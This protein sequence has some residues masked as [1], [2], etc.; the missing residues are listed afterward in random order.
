LHFDVDF[1]YYG[2]GE[3]RTLAIDD[4]M[5]RNDIT[6]IDFIKIAIAGMELSSLKGSRETIEKFKP[7]LAISLYHSVDDY[8]TIPN[9]LASLSMIDEVVIT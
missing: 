1:A 5:I 7:K 4:F 2:E 9:Y 8:A 6:R 3:K